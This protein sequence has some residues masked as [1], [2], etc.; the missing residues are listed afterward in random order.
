MPNEA[1]PR[2]LSAPQSDSLCF[3]TGLGFFFVN[4]VE[5]VLMH[6]VFIIFYLTNE[7]LMHCICFI[8]GDVL[9]NIYDHDQLFFKKAPYHI[10]ASQSTFAQSKAI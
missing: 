8:V 2:P 7:K 1:T 9:C 10:Q 4:F 6:F 3:I 5:A